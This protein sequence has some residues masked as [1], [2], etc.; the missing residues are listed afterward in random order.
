[1]NF[2]ELCELAIKERASD[3]ILSANTPIILRVDGELMQIDALKLT[4]E[5]CRNLIE[6]FL[7]EKQKAL[8]FKRKGVDFSYEIPGLSRFRINVYIQKGTLAATVRPIALNLPK[9]AELNLPP[10]VE[11]L[12]FSKR[13]LILITGPAGSGKST[14]L[15]AMI[16]LINT[17]RKSHIITLEDPIEFHHENKQS[18]IEQRE[19]HVDA[20]S[21]S[22]A[23]ISS[24][25]QTPDVIMI[26]ELRDLE[27]IS[28]AITAAETGHL[29]FATL[30]TI[31]AAQTIHRIIDVFPSGQQAQVR[32]QLAGSLTAIIA[33]QLLPIGYKKGRIPA[34][35]VLI[36][37]SAIRN[38]IINNDIRQIPTSIHT[39]KEEGMQSLNQ[40]LKTLFN[41]GI[42]SF[43]IARAFS[44]SPYD[45]TN[46]V[47][48]DLEPVRKKKVFYKNTFKKL[49]S[50]FGIIK[51]K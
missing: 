18:I 38:L 39:G 37:N 24:L 32:T 42:I 8:L 30:H 35:E 41:K 47:L 43:D 49:F 36:S 21:F 1:L 22:S 19:I 48:S 14:T 5:D 6:S 29:V 27:T 26:G 11:K 40:S 31:D 23:L 28:S 51:G 44:T 4:P 20:E 7:D 3:I 2:R 17:G 34:V 45:F 12:T 10:I 15:A 9:F 16:D 50:G 13:G 33:Q 46:L 25:R